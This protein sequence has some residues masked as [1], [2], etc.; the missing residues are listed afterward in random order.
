MSAHYKNVEDFSEMG[1]HIW[2]KNENFKNK[3]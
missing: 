2:L 1:M 3:G